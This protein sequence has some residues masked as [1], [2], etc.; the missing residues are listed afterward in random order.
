M[1][2]EDPGDLKKEISD[3]DLEE[4]IVAERAMKYT[5]SSLCNMFPVAHFLQKVSLTSVHSSHKCVR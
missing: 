4:K 1:G 5:F 2:S 3:N